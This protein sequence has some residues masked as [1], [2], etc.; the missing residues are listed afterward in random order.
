MLLT[1]QECKM[2]VVKKYFIYL[3]VLYLSAETPFLG[4]SGAVIQVGSFGGR[5]EANR[6]KASL[7]RPRGATHQQNP[8][9]QFT[10][11]SPSPGFHTS[12]TM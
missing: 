4:I 1:L 3:V 10:T 5:P 7:K 2:G 8:E 11:W 9:V 6:M 12:H